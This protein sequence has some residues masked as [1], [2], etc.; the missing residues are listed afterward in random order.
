[1]IS[2]APWVTRLYATDYRQEA[3]EETHRWAT[4]ASDAFSWNHYIAMALGN[5]G[6]EPTDANIA[7]RIAEM[8]RK[9]ES[10]DT[11]NVLRSPIV[12]TS[13]VPLTPHAITGM[14]FVS[15]EVGETL[16]GWKAVMKNVCDSIAPGGH[17]FISALRGM[18]EYEVKRPDGPP[19]VYRCA[20]LYGDH[21]REL[22]PMLGLPNPVVED[23]I[24][25]DPDVGI[26]GIVMV[27]ATKVSA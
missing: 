6:I 4:G 19:D 25:K 24:I 2:I 10:I 7:S 21:F 27:S 14:F 17:L 8:R 11:C 22:L 5:E 13:R 1:M 16:D 3:R 15:G 18:T 20:E 9:I 23:L 12:N 26:P